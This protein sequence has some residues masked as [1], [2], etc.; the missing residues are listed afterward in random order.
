MIFNPFWFAQQIITLQRENAVLKHQ[1]NN[2]LIPALNR[3]IEILNA[4]HEYDGYHHEIQAEGNVIPFPV[5]YRRDGK[6]TDAA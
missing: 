5:N 2:E 4:M 1:V 6:P 3:A